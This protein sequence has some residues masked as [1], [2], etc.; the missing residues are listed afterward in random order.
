[1]N[2]KQIRRNFPLGMVLLV[3]GIGASPARTQLGGISTFPEDSGSAL[4]RHLKELADSP[5]SLSALLGAAKA[6]LDL[7]DP[8]AA[9]TFYARAEDIAPRDGRIKAGIGAA[10]L[11]MEQPVPALKFLE[12]ARALGLPEGVIA[13]D[14]GLAHDLLGDPAQAQRDYAIA[15]RASDTDEVRRRLALSRAISGDRGGALAAIDDQVR[16]GSPAGR[17]IRAFVLALTGD[18]SGATDAARAAMPA[19]AAAMQPFFAR[20]PSLRP[21]E[22]AMAVHFGRFPGDAPP[23]QAPTPV[24]SYAGLPPNVILGGKPD[25]TQTGLARRNPMPEPVSTA[26][27]RRP[28]EAEDRTQLAVRMDALPAITA[29]SYGPVQTRPTPSAPLAAAQPSGTGSLASVIAR[30]QVRA[31]S[32][33]TTPPAP[34]VSKTVTPAPAATAQPLRIS[35]FDLARGYEPRAV[36]RSRLVQ[37]GTSPASTAT[38]QAPTSTSLAAN[39]PA[40]TV[41][42]PAPAAP[43]AAP[44]LAPTPGFGVQGPPDGTRPPSLVL[45]GAISAAPAG[46]GPTEIAVSN[47]VAG[48]ITTIVANATPA[49]AGT[50]VAAAPPLAQ[51]IPASIAPSPTIATVMP[52]ASNVAPPPEAATGQAVVQAIAIPPTVSSS[53]PPVASGLSSGLASLAATIRA[54]PT[55]EPAKR[56]ARQ[57]SSKPAPSKTAEAS[58]KTTTPARAEPAKLKEPS[59]HWV[60]VAG[61]ADKSGLAREFARIRGRAPKLLAGKTAWTTPLRFTNRLLV[62]PFKN[63]GEAQAFVNELAKAELTAFTWTSPAGQEIVKLAAK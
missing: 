14:R 52:P 2:L 41:S 53:V 17:R 57:V 21:A 40:G 13:A 4:N 16:R 9:V 47:R 3:G 55:T 24:P 59:R 12:E 26:S 6:A 8:Q 58:V 20:L 33:Q 1:M 50:T 49:P 54:L 60:Q 18:A 48:P 36:T 63:D 61:T 22:R 38:V 27:R 23:G 5:R 56:P 62:G 19:Q 15:M 32:A 44:S 37:L 39:S 28:G 35:A 25:P 46:V 51:A 45:N 30:P 34:Q 31:E 43:T 29:R 11:A 42:S 10:F 7:G